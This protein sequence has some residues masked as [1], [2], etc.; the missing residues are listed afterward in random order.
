MGEVT[1][2]GDHEALAA[3]INRI[4][5]DPLSYQRST[6]I[7]TQSFDPDA[8]ASAYLELF[9]KLQSGTV[10]SQT[11]EPVAHEKLRQ[12]R[13]SFEVSDANQ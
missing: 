3:A 11:T 9:G 5:D 13:D 10:E 7:I 6:D 12:M 4:F 2:V 8:N 1:P